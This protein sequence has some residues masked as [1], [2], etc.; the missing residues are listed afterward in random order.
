MKFDISYILPVD[1]NI[2]K[3]KCPNFS[4]TVSEVHVSAYILQIFQTIIFYIYIVI[5]KENN[6][7][8]LLQRIHMNMNNYIL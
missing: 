2:N 7:I 1:R 3:I 8:A 6:Y 5:E 4:Q